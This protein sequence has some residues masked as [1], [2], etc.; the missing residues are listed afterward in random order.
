MEPTGEA[1]ESVVATLATMHPNQSSEE[2][3]STGGTSEA[4][5]PKGDGP[6]KERPTYFEGS[7]RAVNHS[8]T[9][10][11]VS[12]QRIACDSRTGSPSPCAMFF[13]ASTNAP[14]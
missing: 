2:P 11:A 12:A 5:C 13:R 10:L 14:S 4:P 1:A 3:W 8:T 9:S 7:I 6:P